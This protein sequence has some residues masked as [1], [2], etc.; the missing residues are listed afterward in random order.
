MATSETAS[1]GTRKRD[2]KGRGKERTATREQQIQMA[3]LLD[4][5]NERLRAA[6]IQYRM[7]M[8]EP[9]EAQG[10]I[11]PRLRKLPPMARG[12]NTDM[13]L[14]DIGELEALKV[15]DECHQLLL[16]ETKEAWRINLQL[17]E[18]LD[19]V[20]KRLTEANEKTAELED[21][22]VNGET[23]AERLAAFKCAEEELAQ[24]VCIAAYPKI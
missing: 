9:T 23:I 21:I 22:V 10:G 8:G 17:K 12:V 18:Q 20:T 19:D 24:K 11:E 1:K 16:I 5:N 3:R 13:I 7:R 4:E 14:T 6:G 15:R 2:A